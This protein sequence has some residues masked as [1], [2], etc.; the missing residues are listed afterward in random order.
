MIDLAL[1]TEYRLDGFIVNMLSIEGNFEHHID[2]AWEIAPAN[3]END[4]FTDAH[5]AEV[6]NAI[7]FLLEDDGYKTIEPIT[8]NDL[9]IDI[10][11]VLIEKV[12]A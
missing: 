9:S 8:E 7:N 10:V 1:Q 3:P 2:W 11:D 12:D 5:H 4:E 6:I